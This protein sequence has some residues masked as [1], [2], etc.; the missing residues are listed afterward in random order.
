[1]ARPEPS[2]RQYSVSMRRRFG[3][4]A[5][6]VLAVQVVVVLWG[7]FVRASKS[8]AGCGEHWPLCNGE[9]LPTAPQLPTIIEFT[10]RITSGLAL[11][12]VAWLVVAAYRTFPPGHTVRKM[13]SWSGFFIITEALIGAALVLLGHTALNPSLS[14]G[15]TLSIHLVNTL[16][17]L[18]TLA[19]TAWWATRDP[20]PSHGSPN[21]H[22]RRAFT[23]A[24]SALLIAGVVGAIAALGDTLF[25]PGSVAESFRQDLGAQAH[26]FVRI[27]I[28]HPILAAAAG[29]YLIVL[30]LNVAGKKSSAPTLKR[31]AVAVIALVA[32]QFAVG[33]LNILL[34]VPIP[35]QIVHL[36]FADALWLSFVL[37]GAETLR[38]TFQAK[39]WRAAAD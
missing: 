6:F 35:M 9:L 12:A 5:W 19:L 33:V 31:L 27:R 34:L 15:I 28:L 10:H 14:R 20:A 21:S 38:P 2:V 32:A 8:G 39:E 22:L 11:I 17:L 23:V 16:F 26:P 30:A 4:L 29:L 7:A 3:H 13:A 18:G 37:F 36:F 25:A 24:A 1:M